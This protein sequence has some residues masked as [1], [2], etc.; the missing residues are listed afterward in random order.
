MLNELHAWRFLTYV[1]GRIQQCHDSH[2]CRRDCRTDHYRR[3]FELPIV[4]RNPT[5]QWIPTT[6]SHIR[7]DVYCCER[8]HQQPVTAVASRTHPTVVIELNIHR[9]VLE[10]KIDAVIA[11]S[12]HVI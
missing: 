8:F 7:F 1:L 3:G 12:C 9:G 10:P 4:W 6:C 2:W 11:H 5:F